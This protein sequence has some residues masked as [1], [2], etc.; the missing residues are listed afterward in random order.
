MNEN[1]ALFIEEFGRGNNKEEISDEFFARYEGI[2]PISL[3]D[4]LRIEGWQSYGNGIFWTVNPEKYS[5]VVDSWLGSIPALSDSSYHIFARS[6]FGEFYAIREATSKVIT[7][8]CPQAIVIARKN[9]A[10]KAKSP[11]LE[12]QVFFS[13]AQ[14]NDFDLFDDNE[15]PLFDRAV[16]KL[17]NI[18]SNEIYGLEPII[19]LGGFPSLAHLVKVRMDVHID[20]IRQL[21]TPSLRVLTV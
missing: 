11:E 2:F 5:W 14:K 12:A 10:I 13:S 21:S 17:G 16:K 19:P 4:F 15:K 1:F 6:A 9:Y 18:S 7:I 3:I 8:S 20:I